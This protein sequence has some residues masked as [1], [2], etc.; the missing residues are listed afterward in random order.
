MRQAVRS[1]LVTVMML[2]ELALLVFLCLY[3]LIILPVTD[4]ADTPLTAQLFWGVILINFTLAALTVCLHGAG[5][6]IAERLNEDLMYH[7][8]IRPFGIA[9]G[10][11]LSGFILSALFFS[12]TFPILTLIYLLRGVDLRTVA[13]AFLGS[14]L[15]VQT[16]HCFFLAFLAGVR[17]PMDIGVRSLPLFLFVGMV[18][19]F[20]TMIV[21]HL[22]GSRYFDFS[23]LVFWL[24]LFLLVPAALLLLT[25]CQFAPI[26]SNRMLP[27][28]IVMTA[29]FVTLF[30]ICLLFHFLLPH[31]Y[32]FNHV[33][34]AVLFSMCPFLFFCF[35]AVCE[36]SE[37]GLRYRAGI[38]KSPLFRLLVFPFYTGDCNAILWLLLAILFGI[39]AITLGGGFSESRIR[40]LFP[41][42][43]TYL[44]TFDYAVLAV[45]L[46]NALRRFAWVRR[47]FGNGRKKR[48]STVSASRPAVTNES[49][50]IVA[51]VLLL[52]GTILS[53]FWSVV[54]N[55]IEPNQWKEMFVF[56]PNPAWI[57][58]MDAG[59][60]AV[61]QVKVALAVFLFLLPPVLLWTML[62]LKRFKPIEPEK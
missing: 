54:W 15:L 31:S 23:M 26:S 59:D 24:F 32:H 52:T 2:S 16:L 57:Y 55:R 27:V 25:A 33:Y 53:V 6:L 7:S 45:F 51:V 61:F 38:P 62:R 1:R 47:I 12:M 21:T 46:R 37:Y 60:G 43:S 18:L 10:K 17:R 56:V 30:S 58:D 50:W 39:V 11:F 34:L 19:F 36:R 8:T 49:T 13:F 3:E 35:V 40:D 41:V 28:R 44:L 22:D 48:K 14:F 5:R 4:G 42:F 9:T 20:C 29:L